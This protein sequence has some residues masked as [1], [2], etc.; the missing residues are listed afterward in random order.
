MNEAP[1]SVPSPLS[2]SPVPDPTFFLLNDLNRAYLA[3]KT[4]RPPLPYSSK[5][6]DRGWQF[7][8]GGAVI[9]I[10]LTVCGGF[11]AIMARI[12]D[13]RFPDLPD[14]PPPTISVMLI[15]L[16]GLGVIGLIVVIRDVREARQKSADTVPP[17]PP[18]EKPVGVLP[19]RPTGQVFDGTVVQAEKIVKQVQYGTEEKI[20]VRYQFAAPGGV[21]TYGYAA[22][23]SE[24]ASDG[25]APAPGTPVKIYYE[26]EKKHYLL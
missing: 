4:A 23:L 22:G 15:F 1:T 19:S 18:I 20:G 11:D 16:L 6:N 14:F 24:D 25:M 8:V 12:P 21:I 17:S 7:I 5:P 9:Y 13:I 2:E 3:G 26:G 10:L